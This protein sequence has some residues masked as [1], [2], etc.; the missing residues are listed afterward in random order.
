MLNPIFNIINNIYKGL[1]PIGLGLPIHEHLNF[2]TLAVTGWHDWVDTRIMCGDLNNPA[3][4]SCITLWNHGTLY[5]YLTTAQQ[6]KISSSSADDTL[7]GTGANVLLLYGLDAN[8]NRITETIQLNGQTPVTSANSYIRVYQMEVIPATGLVGTGNKGNIYCYTGTASSGV[9]TNANSVLSMV[10]YN[11]TYSKGCNK[12]SQCTYTIPAGYFGIVR[13][14]TT[15][16]E[17]GGSAEFSIWAS[18]FKTNCP[19]IWTMYGAIQLYQANYINELCNPFVVPP[20]T[21]IEIRLNNG[22]KI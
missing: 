7:L 8:Y 19:R 1:D 21:D 4:N 12:S 5:N 20:K 6:V 11:S 16:I 14:L 18:P 17:S 9:P 13:K 22:Y 3:N 15:N 2:N 10:N